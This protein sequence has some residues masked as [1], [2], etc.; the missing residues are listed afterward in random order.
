MTQLDLTGGYDPEFDWPLQS[1]PENPEMRES[2]SFWVS[3]N[4]G[5][6]GFP[7]MCIEVVAKTWEDRGI[8]ANIA[9]PDGRVLIGSNG[10]PAREAKSA[11]GR[12]VELNAGPLSFELVEPLKHWRM[13]F[14]GPAYESTVAR[15][16]NAHTGGPSRNVRIYVDAIAAVPAWSP[17]ELA[18]RSGDKSTE[19][20]MGAVGGHRHEQLFR[21]TGTFSIEGETE[22]RFEGTGL[23]IRR[24]GVRDIG[25][26]PGHC[27]MSAVFPSGKAFGI[28]SFPERADGTPA[29]SEGFVFDGQEKIYV[30]VLQIP[31]MESFTPHGGDVGIVLQT[32]DGETIRIDGKTHDSTFIA[33]GNPMFGNWLQPQGE[34]P[35]GVPLP[36]HQGGARYTWDGET[37]YGMIERSYPA[38]KIKG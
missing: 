20:A 35:H 25:A 13:V 14:D 9:F 16:I 15:S 17:G 2:V 7:R 11:N 19:L 21:C 33:L 18:A 27:W 30:K 6:F 4:A 3:D 5:R 32:D 36:F 31:W 1:R 10:Y 8:E 12:I 22:Q 26:F 23:K 24:T 34:P 29:Y 37:T 28:Q 38:D